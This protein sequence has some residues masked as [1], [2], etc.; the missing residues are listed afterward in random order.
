MWGCGIELRGLIYYAMLGYCYAMLGTPHYTKNQ[1]IINTK[2]VEQKCI[3]HRVSQINK[4]I[5]MAA[6]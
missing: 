2:K 4:Q 6:F 5:Y 1:C 3:T